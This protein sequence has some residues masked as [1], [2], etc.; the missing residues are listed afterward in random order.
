MKRHVF[1]HDGLHATGGEEKAKAYLKE[2]ADMNRKIYGA[3]S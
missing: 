2:S 3:P 1:G